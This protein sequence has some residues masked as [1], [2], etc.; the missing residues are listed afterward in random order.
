MSAVAK[1]LT[2]VELL[3]AILLGLPMKDLLRA[4]HVRD[5]WRQVI[6]GSNAIQKALF[7]RPG[8]AAEAAIDAR[9]IEYIK[10]D[11]TTGRIAVNPWICEYE[12]DRVWDYDVRSGLS[13]SRR[14]IGWG[15]YSSDFAL[16]SI[17]QPPMKLWMAIT[18]KSGDE[19]WGHQ[20]FGMHPDHVVTA[21][22][23]KVSHVFKLVHS[24][25]K[26]HAR[27]LK[28]LA[29]KRVVS[30]VS[31]RIDGFKVQGTTSK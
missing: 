27:K 8:T 10:A 5:H 18:Y 15:V 9:C 26:E 2:T 16:M 17:T 7:L 12:C 31:V 1:V 29:S 3:E 6:V 20:Y 13:I 11:G 25:V 19:H 4:Q 14:A 22:T 23:T 24:A 28:G 21:S 30:P